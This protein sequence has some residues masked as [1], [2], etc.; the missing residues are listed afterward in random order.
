MKKRIANSLDEF[1][2]EKTLTEHITPGLSM[3]I[4][5]K[6]GVVKKILEEQLGNVQKIIFEAEGKQY[7][8]F[9]NGHQFIISKEIGVNDDIEI[10]NPVKNQYKSSR[11]IDTEE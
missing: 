11:I 10:L 2:N 3:Y 4:S 6:N 7:E 5:G 8:A 1:I 9:F